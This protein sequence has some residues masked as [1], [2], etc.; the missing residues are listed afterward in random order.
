VE[1]ALFDF[2]GTITKGDTIFTFIQYYHGKKKYLFGCMVLFPVFFLYCLKILNHHKAKELT[3]SY[4]FRNKDRDE[5]ITKAN[6]FTKEI[7]PKMILDSAMEKIKWHLERDHKVVIVTGSLNILVENWCRE[8]GLDLISSRLD[9]SSQRLSGHLAGI[10]CF[11]KEKVVKIREKYNLYD[12]S[13]IYAYGDSKDD[14]YMF[15][16]AHESYFKLFS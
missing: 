16:L 12:Y 1:L 14:K 4:F 11:S 10:N 5:F 6:D 13:R 2:D 15:G 3:L 8:H 9:M 7:L